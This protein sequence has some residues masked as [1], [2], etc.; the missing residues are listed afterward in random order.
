MVRT[1]NLFGLAAIGLI[2][3]GLLASQLNAQT[4]FMVLP[5]GA[6]HGYGIGMQAPIYFLAALFCIF[7]FLYSIGYIP[8]SPTM[9][10][11]HFWVS[12][13]SVL[14]CILGAASFVGFAFGMTEPHLGPAG[15]LVAATFVLGILT[16]VSMQAWF[17]VDLARAILKM[18]SA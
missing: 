8:F 12:F 7:A 6:T 4:G 9:V 2:A 5:V 15:T 3:L 1:D 18:H 17:A 10:T 16:F 13:G 11:W 14:V